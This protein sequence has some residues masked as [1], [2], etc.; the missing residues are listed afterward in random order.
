MFTVVKS[1]PMD[2]P[3]EVCISFWG[4]IYV[5]GGTFR[6]LKGVIIL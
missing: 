3:S 5:E 6:S 1:P 4:G 2:D